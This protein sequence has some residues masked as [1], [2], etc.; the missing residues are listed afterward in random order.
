MHS[1]GWIG[2]NSVERIQEG[3]VPRSQ[4]GKSSPSGTREEFFGGGYLGDLRGKNFGG[5]ASDLAC[6]TL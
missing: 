3:A 4:L 6:L 1:L 2:I 5:G